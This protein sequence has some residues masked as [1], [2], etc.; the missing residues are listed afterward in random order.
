MKVIGVSGGDT[1]IC[2][3][4]HTEIEKF[5]GLYYEEME[6]LKT[7]DVVDLEKGYDYAGKTAEAMRKTQEFIQANREIVEAI[8]NGLSVLDATKEAPCPK[9]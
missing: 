1:Y 6:D 3:V 2:E 9:N 5:M 4:S 8:L 7:G